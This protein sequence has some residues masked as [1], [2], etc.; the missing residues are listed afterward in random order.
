MFTNIKIN[1]ANVRRKESETLLFPLFHFH[2]DWCFPNYHNSNTQQKL[3][4]FYSEF[5]NKFFLHYL[6]KVK[7]DT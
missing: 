4:K 6:I 5:G 1:W 3:L 2:L 7:I